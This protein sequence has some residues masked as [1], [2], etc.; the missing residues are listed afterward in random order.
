MEKTNKKIFGNL[1]LEA[2][3]VSENELLNAIE[4][5]KKNGG[6]IGEILIKQGIISQEDVIQVLE[7][8]V[9]HM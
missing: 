8:L 4:I 2:G 7:W 6:K 3:L 9:Y 5:Q 1:L